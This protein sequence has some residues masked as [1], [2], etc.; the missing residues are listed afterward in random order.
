MAA[1]QG[2]PGTTRR[3]GGVGTNAMGNEESLYI[4]IMIYMVCIYIYDIY[5]IY[6]M[7]IY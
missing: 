7:C 6:G 5:D 3:L 4:Y 2:H 1:F